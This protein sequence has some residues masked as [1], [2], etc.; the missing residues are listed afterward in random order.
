MKNQPKPL[1]S[2]VNGLKFQARYEAPQEFKLPPQAIAIVNN[3][4][5]DLKGICTAW[6]HTF[7]DVA[8]EQAAKKQWVQALFENNV[9]TQHQINIGMKKARKLSKPWFPSSGEFIEWCKPNLEDYGLPA[10]DE[11]LRIWI[12]RQSKSYPA[13]YVAAQATGSWALKSMNHKDL[14]ALFSRNYEIAC[15][16]V[17]AG[18]D[19]SEEI[20]LALPSEVFVPVPATKIYKAAREKLRQ[21]IGAET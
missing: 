11:A 6:Q 2:I 12:N 3:L 10:V 7:T 14:F 20:P 15:N 16:R 19:L 9:I 4:F 8:I 5:N 1:S 17:M 21:T 13:I 18:E